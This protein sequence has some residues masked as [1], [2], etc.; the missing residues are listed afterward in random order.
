MWNF[1]KFWKFLKILKNS[2]KIKNI[3]FEKTA[4]IFRTHLEYLLH[5]RN[6]SRPW[7]SASVSKS[8]CWERQKWLNPFHPYRTTGLSFFKEGVK[9]CFFAV[10]QRKTLVSLGA[11][12]KWDFKNPWIS[13]FKTFCH[14][15]LIL[16]VFRNSPY[17]KVFGRFLKFVQKYVFLYY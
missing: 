14:F 16:A 17:F 5:P 7:P 1:W 9:C 4:Q 10:F 6:I 8:P 2:E 13:L 12:K 15:F 3:L 11:G